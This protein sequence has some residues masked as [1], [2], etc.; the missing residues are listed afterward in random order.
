MA[1][2]YV[3]LGMPFSLGGNRPVSPEYDPGAMSLG[4]FLPLLVCTIALFRRILRKRTLSIV[5]SNP[6]IGLAT[7]IAKAYW[8][9]LW[10]WT[11]VLLVAAVAASASVTDMAGAVRTMSAA[12]LATSLGLLASID[13]PFRMRK[14]PSV[15]KKESYWGWIVLLVIF[16]S[17]FAF[18]LARKASRPAGTKERT[19]YAAKSANPK[20]TSSTWGLPVQLG[21]PKES[22][23]AALGEHSLN[24]PEF[25]K[26]RR[27]LRDD[28]SFDFKK[29][30]SN[31]EV[32][33]LRIETLSSGEGEREMTLW[34]QR[35]GFV[36][37][38]KDGRV[39]SI[40][41]HGRRSYD[42][43][44]P[45]HIEQYSGPI[46]MGITTND[47]FDSL[48]RKLGPPSKSDTSFGKSHHQWRCPPF[49]IEISTWAKDTEER[50]TLWKQGEIT[51]SISISS[52][53]P[54]LEVEAEYAR[55]QKLIALSGKNLTP[56]EIFHLYSDRVVQVEAI[57]SKGEVAQIG[58]GFAWRDSEIL[59]NR[60]IVEQARQA[61]I[62]RHGAYEDL[63]IE[64][65]NKEQ[66]WAIYSSR[67]TAALPPVAI[68]EALP[69]IGDEVVV[70]GNPQGLKNSLSTGIVAGLRKEGNGIWIQITAPISKGSSGS[71][72]FDS[73]GRLLGLATMMLIDGQNLNFA[74]FVKQAQDR[75]K[76]K[77]GEDEQNKWPLDAVQ[78][79][80]LY[81]EEIFTK[82]SHSTAEVQEWS[83]KMIS[84]YSDPKD[85]EDI[86]ERTATELYLLKDYATAIQF[87]KK[88][89][90]LVGENWVD[91]QSIGD[92]L[93]DMGKTPE[94]KATYLRAI[95]IAISTKESDPDTDYNR[96]TSIAN[97]YSLIGNEEEARRWALTALSKYPKGH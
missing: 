38:F 27:A 48:Q 41:V 36:I 77:P 12:I 21:Q 5:A 29:L 64:R 88:K 59:T 67:L 70:I 76:A 87:Y 75:A 51:D 71:P 24:F 52:L 26:R 6:E 34:W 74:T 96:L 93:S 4:A 46:V 73:K 11:L 68:A 30:Y 80:P 8:G 81:I 83:E 65:N 91:F 66:D 32:E 69:E 42:P 78:E 97:M 84:R 33:K 45:L 39:S 25:M 43:E 95:E 15:S 55:Q 86:F 49:L 3:I 2:L 18:V 1:Y 62:Q 89:M 61:K 40:S 90:Q 10:R 63:W 22:V 37:D 94:S 92:C 35:Q 20:L 9:F 50:G 14:L 57:N 54:V 31:L 53:A 7:L 16:I 58:T 56:K 28:P 72:V 17:L 19:S 47:N 85:Q 60:H 44:D 13:V 23:F 82:K 79:D